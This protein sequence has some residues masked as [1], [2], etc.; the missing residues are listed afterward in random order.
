MKFSPDSKLLAS[1]DA[2]G[3]VKLWDTSGNQLAQLPHSGEVININFSPDEK[4]LATMSN[5][6][7]IR[8]WQLGGIE[9]LMAQNC[10]WIRVYLQMS[11]NISNSDRYLCDG[12]GTTQ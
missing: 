5:D 8:L 3:M 12:I 2:N 11:P 7:T 1:G 6:G 4:Q 10:D 9:E